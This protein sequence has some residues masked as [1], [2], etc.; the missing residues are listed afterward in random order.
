MRHLI[1]SATLL[2]SIAA[3][4]QVSGI[5]ITLRAD[6]LKDGTTYT[7]VNCIMPG[8]PAEKAGIKHNMWVL[9]VDGR[10]CKNLSVPAVTELIRGK[11]GT[12]IELLLAD[13]A[14]G[15]RAR[16]FSLVRKAIPLPTRR[17]AKH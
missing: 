14:S 15:G 7:R 1:L 2:L 12:P 13:S 10:N 5:G 11:A 16:K 6:T 9:N 8:G 4:A 17:Q 3:H